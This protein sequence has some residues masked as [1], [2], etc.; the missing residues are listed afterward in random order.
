MDF[1]GKS[2]TSFYH[3]PLN[4]LMQW[5]GARERYSMGGLCSG[6]F[7]RDNKMTVQQLECDFTN[8]TLYWRL[9]IS[10]NNTAVCRGLSTYNHN[11]CFNK[12]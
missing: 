3:S 11:I 10:S 2:V 12:F 7:Q 4:N 6:A 1:E 9:K 8:R 5:T